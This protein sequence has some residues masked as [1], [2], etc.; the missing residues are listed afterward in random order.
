MLTREHQ[1]QSLLTSTWIALAATGCGAPAD[2]HEVT[3][4]LIN[5]STANP[6]LSVES[7]EVRALVDGEIEGTALI[8]LD[9]LQMENMHVYGDVR[10][11]VLG[12]DNEGLVVSVGRSRIVTVEPGV[13][14][15]VT[16]T[17]LP[18][19]TFVPIDSPMVEQRSYHNTTTTSDGRLLIYGGLNP[20][21]LSMLNTIEIYDPADGT[22]VQSAANL[23]IGSYSAAQGWTSE[24]QLIINGGVT[25]LDGNSDP[26]YTTSTAIYDPSSDTIQQV[27]PMT[28]ARASHCLPT[29]PEENA[30]AIGGNWDLS[31]QI[32]RLSPDNSSNSG[33]GWNATSNIQGFDTGSVTSCI[34]VSDSTV[35]I[36]G[37]SA[38][39]TGTFTMPESSETGLVDLSN[40]LS[41][42]VPG[43][44]LPAYIAYGW[45]MI[46]TVL[47]NGRVWIHGGYDV[48]NNIVLDLSREFD[49]ETMSFRE[50]SVTDLLPRMWGQ[51]GELTSP[52]FYAIGCGGTDEPTWEF[53]NT[54]VELFNI[55]TGDVTRTIFLDRERPGCKMDVL[56]DGSVIVTGGFAP[57]D[58]SFTD[59]V[60]MMPWIE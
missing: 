58:D 19:N 10:F 55:S 17:F 14:L 13:G 40:A 42:S 11:E 23:T 35:F 29:F 56:G 59:A 31:G 47:D 28:H 15:A 18:A 38:N 12:L 34:Q 7:I 20:S 48:D 49:I 36:Q 39:S 50:S 21:F 33:W 30:V 24:G 25:G 1:I 37:A 2:S 5:P 27:A 51:V 9:E 60:I 16:V 46:K 57:G 52:D 45:G 54:A 6:M 22:F 26:V 8:D 4:E 53:P 32:E 3:L 41:P 44:S 43:N